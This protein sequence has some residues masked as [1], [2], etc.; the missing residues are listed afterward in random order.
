RRPWGGPGVVRIWVLPSLR[1]NVYPGPR[2]PNPGLASPL[3]GEV[4][5]AAAGWGAAVKPEPNA[6]TLTLPSKWGGE[7]APGRH[8]G[9]PKQLGRE[10]FT[11]PLA[12]EVGGAAAGWGRPL[13]LTRTPPP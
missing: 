10:S 13:N 12:G 7:T 4:G 11:S 9:P 2:I 5:G 3:A 8:P 6:P 1:E